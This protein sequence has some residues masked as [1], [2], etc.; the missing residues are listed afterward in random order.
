MS[1]VSIAI[2]DEPGSAYVAAMFPDIFE[3]AIFA[4]YRSMSI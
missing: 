2:F 4:L 3:A 1:N